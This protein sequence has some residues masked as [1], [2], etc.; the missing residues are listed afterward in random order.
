MLQVRPANTRISLHILTVWSESSQGFLWV[1]KYP[2]R[3]Q[4]ESEDSDPLDESICWSPAH[5][6]LWDYSHQNFVASE[7]LIFQFKCM[8]LLL[9]LL[10]LL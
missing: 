2:K 7:Q 1:A 5:I 3:L 10:L 4:A 6:V 8:P 9:L